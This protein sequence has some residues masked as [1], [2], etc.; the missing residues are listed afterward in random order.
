[1]QSKLPGEMALEG[2][3]EAVSESEGLCAELIKWESVSFLVGLIEGDVLGVAVEELNHK[4][5]TMSKLKI[6]II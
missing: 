6:M 3:E 2:E 1:M 4:N 5:S